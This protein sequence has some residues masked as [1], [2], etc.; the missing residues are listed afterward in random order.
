MRAVL[1]LA[2]SC[3]LCANAVIPDLIRRAVVRWM[4]NLNSMW[5]AVVVHSG[6]RSATVRLQYQL[7]S[8]SEGNLV[9]CRNPYK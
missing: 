5:W 1:V 9:L 4:G 3:L 2:E 6:A 7:W 8:F